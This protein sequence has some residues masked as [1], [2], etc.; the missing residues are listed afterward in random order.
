MS[1]FLALYDLQIN[2][3][4]PN[5]SMD[6]IL[7]H[8]INR[9]YESLNTNPYFWYGPIGGTVIRNAAYAFSGRLFANYSAEYPIDGRLC[10]PHSLP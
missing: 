3:T 2:S 6:V 7:E 1:Q 4:E 9:Y 8:N 5:Y 10:K